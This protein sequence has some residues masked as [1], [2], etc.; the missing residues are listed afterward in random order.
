MELTHSLV[1]RAMLSLPVT[2]ASHRRSVATGDKR[3]QL[4]DDAFEDSLTLNSFLFLITKLEWDLSREEMEE[5]RAFVTWRAKL[6]KLIWFLD[7]YDAE[8]GLKA[9]QLWEVQT[10]ALGHWRA[11][12]SCVFGAITNMLAYAT[13]SP[14][15]AT[16]RLGAP[17]LRSWEVAMPKA[18]WT[19]RGRRSSSSAL[20]PQAMR[21]H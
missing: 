6:Q 17:D 21:T 13:P 14:F 18:S 20:Y 15:T 10:N 19:R 3:I 9:L 16:R 8:S 7:K 11:V 1:F 12:N 5:R 4:V 2:D